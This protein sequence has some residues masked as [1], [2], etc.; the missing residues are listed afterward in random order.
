MSKNDDR[1]TPEDKENAVKLLDRLSNINRLEFLGN[2]IWQEIICVILPSLI[3][4]VASLPASNSSALFLAGIMFLTMLLGRIN[5]FHIVLTGLFCG[6]MLAGCFGLYKLSS[7]LQH[8]DPDAKV[9]FRR[10]GTG[11]SR[12][13]DKS[14]DYEEIIRTAD[15]G[16]KEY[17]TALDRIRQPYGAKIAIK[18]GGLFGKGPGRS[19]QKYKVPVIYE[20]YIFSFI[21]EEYGLLFGGLIIFILYLSLL[22]RGSEVIARAHEVHRQI[23]AK[24]AI[25]AEMPAE[26]LKSLTFIDT[27]RTDFEIDHKRIAECQVIVLRQSSDHVRTVFHCLEQCM[28]LLNFQIHQ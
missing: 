14:I 25:D 21:I 4:V 15:K 19:T 23:L 10:I 11:V 3:I 18:E 12:V 26:D 9:L 20:D 7:G 13:L 16:S 24:S 27:S 8:N 28:C 1:S 22:A 6:V 2:K 5:F 17:Q